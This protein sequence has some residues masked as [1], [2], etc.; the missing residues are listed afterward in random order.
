MLQLVE[1]QIACNCCPTRACKGEINTLL[2]HELHANELTA[3]NLETVLQYKAEHF[4]QAS[5]EDAKKCT[6]EQIL[7][8]SNKDVRPTPIVQQHNS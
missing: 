4:T 6:E 5:N 2:P 7:Q 3:L 8:I 1:W